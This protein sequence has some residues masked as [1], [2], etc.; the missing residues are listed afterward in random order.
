MPSLKELK[1]QAKEMGLK[2]YSKLRKDALVE[3]IEKEQ[4]IKKKKL[5]RIQYTR[6]RKGAEKKK[7]LKKNSEVNKTIFDIPSVSHTEQQIL[8]KLKHYVEIDVNDVN[9]GDKL[10]YRYFIYNPDKKKYEFKSGGFALTNRKSDKFLTLAN[11][12]QGF[13]WS[14][15]KVVDGNPTIFFKLDKTSQLNTDMKDFLET[16]FDNKDKTFSRT[17]Q[18]IAVSTDFKEFHNSS[19]LQSLLAQTGGSE[20]GIRKAFRE[21]R[22]KF[23]KFYIT[24][25]S[26]EDVKD[27]KEDYDDIDFIVEGTDINKRVQELLN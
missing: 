18:Y 25:G 9:P 8:D 14:V 17:Q 7:N 4:K 11:I 5:K 6:A 22:N 15:Q 3:F 27:M 20:I 13:S 12:S 19:D 10:W 23:K 24:R 2:G 26:K 21:K 16:Y 1:A